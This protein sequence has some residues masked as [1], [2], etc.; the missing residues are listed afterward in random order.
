MAVILAIFG[1]GVALGPFIGG[2]IVESTTWRWVFY[3]NLPIGGTSLV[4]MFIFLR[5]QY[6][7]DKT[8]AER[9]SRI[10][11]IGNGI[12][13]A[14]TV[15]ILYALTY[16]GTVYSWSSWHTLVPLLLG[17]LG[18]FLFLGYEISGLPLEP[19]MPIRLFAHRTSILVLINTFLNS[20]VYFWIVYFLPVYFQAVALYSPSRAG[21]S[22]LPQA[23]FG[24]PGAAIA[25]ISLSRWGKFMPLHFSGFAIQTIGMGLL[26]MQWEETTIAEWATFQCVA[27]LGVGIVIDTLLPA[28]QAPLSESDQA[29]ATSAW[30]LVRAFGS[31]W[32]IAIP[33]VIFSNR[34][35]EML[36]TIG[37]PAART[38][39]ANGG[40]Y[41]QASAAFI[42]QFDPLTQ[43]QIRVV[44]REALKRVF[45]IGAIFSGL[46]TFLVLLEREVPL[47]KELDTRYGLEKDA[48][49][50]SGSNAEK[51]V[52]TMVP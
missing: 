32:G 24:T 43:A 38:V 7:H 45:W 21:Y 10:D 42:H 23:L 4:V 14:G 12:L 16:A 15:A 39:L 9:I 20:T 37:D 1:I 25:A 52:T 35:D 51:S 22:L 19:V 49:T 33:A 17:F 11:F 27:A 50:S 44:Y 3:M 31:I 34:F 41:Q 18:L 46:A 6:D 47:R 2:A 48:K 8:F 36:N 5:V 13:I 40:A 29:A 30:G 28:F 26:S